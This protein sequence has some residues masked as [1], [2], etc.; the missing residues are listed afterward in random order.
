M[1]EI[2]S[3]FGAAGAGAG[4]GA[5]TGAG[6]GAVTTAAGAFAFCASERVI[7]LDVVVFHAHAGV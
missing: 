2:F 6:A 5:A 4:D 1:A 3:F 7:G